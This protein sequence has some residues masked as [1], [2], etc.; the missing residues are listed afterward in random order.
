MNML[1]MPTSR[2]RRR[3]K[4]SDRDLL[5]SYKPSATAEAQTNPVLLGI[6]DA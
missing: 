2:E 4:M 1:A 5:D 3:N 6:K